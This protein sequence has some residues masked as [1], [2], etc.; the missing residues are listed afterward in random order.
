MDSDLLG[1]PEPD[2]R[3]TDVLGGPNRTG[4]R[5]TSSAARAGESLADLLGRGEFD[6]R[7]TGLLGRQQPDPRGTDLLGN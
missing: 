4:A 2:E 5:P 6:E 3:A 7:V 1:G